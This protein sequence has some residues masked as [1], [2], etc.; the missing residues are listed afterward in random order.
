[1]IFRFDENP[2]FSN[3]GWNLKGCRSRNNGAWWDYRNRN[4]CIQIF[5]SVLLSSSSTVW[6]DWQLMWKR[7]IK[8]TRLNWRF[9]LGS[10]SPDSHRRLRALAFRKR[11]SLYL[12]FKYSTKCLL[13]LSLSLVGR[14]SLTLGNGPTNRHRKKNWEKKQI[15]NIK[16]E[17]RRIQNFG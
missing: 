4:I 2:D 14:D 3:F 15:P 11:T 10:A 7:A 17:R 16:V 1:M 6:F 9:W 12:Y 5:R 8:V 13:S